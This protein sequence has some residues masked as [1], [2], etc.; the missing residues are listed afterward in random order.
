[1]F[2]IWEKSY[3][4]GT[5]QNSFYTV[6]LVQSCLI[7]SIST[8]HWIVLIIVLCSNRQ[9]QKARVLIDSMCST[10]HHEKPIR[11][12]CVSLMELTIFFTIVYYCSQIQMHE[13]PLGSLLSQIWRFRTNGIMLACIVCTLSIIITD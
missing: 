2:D 5:I 12:K 6:L 1:M 9:V 10:W 8:L 3:Y 7:Y 11:L 13:M 4:I